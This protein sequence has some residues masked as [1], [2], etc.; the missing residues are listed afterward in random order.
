MS[1]W[2]QEDIEGSEFVAKLCL[3]HDPMDYSASG[4]SVEKN[5]GVV[6]ISSSKGS[7]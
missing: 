6:T 5:T 4:S 1:Q 3:T 2:I 7:S